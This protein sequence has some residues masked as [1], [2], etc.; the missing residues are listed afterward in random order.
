MN[1][2]AKVISRT[3]KGRLRFNLAKTAAGRRV[4]GQMKIVVR[5]IYPKGTKRDTAAP[6]IRDET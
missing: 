4:L 3:S 1:V 2:R 5:D 6:W